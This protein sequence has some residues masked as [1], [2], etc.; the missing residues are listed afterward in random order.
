MEN[1]EIILASAS[2]RRRE[3]LDQAGVVYRA[4]SADIDE[5][6]GSQ[7][8]P[9]EYVSRMACEKALAVRAQDR[10]GLPVLAADTAVVVDERILGK[11]ADRK[12]AVNMLKSLSGREHK[13]YSAVALAIAGEDVR[14]RLN[15]SSVVFDELDEMWIEAYC[16][17]GEPF[18][19]AGAYAIQGRAATRI[20]LLVGSHSG[21]MGLPLFETC[22]LLRSA[23]L[24]PV[25]D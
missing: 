1:V 18:D 16:D 6:C 7:E 19:K 25:P 12:D 9:S 5:I 10:A 22:E 14:V 3:L 17:S 11:P 2:P 8:S 15:I 23:G 20:S 21:V 24:D 13:V 4:L